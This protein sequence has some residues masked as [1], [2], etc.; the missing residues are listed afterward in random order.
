M[1]VC[2]NCFTDVA[3]DAIKCPECGYKVDTQSSNVHA[4]KPITVV[5]DR[6]LIGRVLG[7]GGFGVTYKAKDLLTDDICAVKE[8]FPTAWAY[9]E[10][11]S[12]NIVAKSDKEKVNFDSGKRR[13]LDEAKLLNKFKN[14]ENI[15]KVTNFFASNNTAY[16]VMEFLDGATL[17]HVMNTKGGK[18]PFDICTHVF[19]AVATALQRLH[20]KDVLHRDISPENVFITKKSEIKLIDFGSAKHSIKEADSSLSVFVKPGLAPIEQYYSNGNQGPW[21]DIYALAS[22]FYQMVSGIA[23]PAAPDRATED[24]LKPLKNVST[25]VSNEWSRIIDKALSMEAVDRYQSIAEL[26]DDVDKINTVIHTQADVK[27]RTEERGVLQPQPPKPLPPPPPKSHPSPVKQIP[28]KLSPC[29]IIE[30]SKHKDMRGRTR[31]ELECDREY[32]LGRSVQKCDI[33]VDMSE[34]V[35]RRH[36]LIK[37]DSVLKNFVIKDISVNGVFMQTGERMVRDRYVRVNLGTLIFL[38]SKDTAIR[39]DLRK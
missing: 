36:C 22:M 35:S 6:Y 33:V 13:F 23:V 9:R 24:K 8:Y 37:F 20:N 26:L 1:D 32:C 30:K 29:I 34:F 17:R 15:V 12:N 2:P 19:T 4:L 28:Q 7:S 5:A 11:D 3:N 14:E 21:T 38:G 25:S 18:L 39:M 27:I 10:K 31:I 16:L